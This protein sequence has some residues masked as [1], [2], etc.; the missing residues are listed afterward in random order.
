MCVAVR[1]RHG[2]TL[3]TGLLE[4]LCF[5]GVVFGWA[6]LVFILK[7]EGFFGSLCVNTTGENATQVEGQFRLLRMLFG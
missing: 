1:V 2:L 5:C 4:C 6:S 3:A 7:V